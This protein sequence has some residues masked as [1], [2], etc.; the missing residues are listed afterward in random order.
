MS[1]KL[2]NSFIIHDFP[3]TKIKNKIKCPK[4]KQNITKTQNG[5]GFPC[6]LMMMAVHL[7]YKDIFVGFNLYICVL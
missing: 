7:L 6:P 5:I 3:K 1:L 2:I 4:A